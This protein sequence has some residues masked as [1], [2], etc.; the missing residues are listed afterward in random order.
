MVHIQYYKNDPLLGKHTNHSHII[1][2]QNMHIF[3]QTLCQDDLKI[4]FPTGICS[5]SNFHTYLNYG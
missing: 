4:L 5:F 2:L 1:I 3:F